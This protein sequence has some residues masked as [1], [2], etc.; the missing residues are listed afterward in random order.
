MTNVVVREKDQFPQNKQCFLLEMRM[1]TTLISYTLERKNERKWI[2][3]AV[4]LEQLFNYSNC[5]VMQA[6][7]IYGG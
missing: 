1:L 2:I 6:E 4:F 7:A 3:E 5:T